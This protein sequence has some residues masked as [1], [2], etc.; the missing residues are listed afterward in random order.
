MYTLCVHVYEWVCYIFRCLFLCMHYCDLEWVHKRG[1][2][3]PTGPTDKLEITFKITQTV[4]V[5][6][7]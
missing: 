1:S 2:L 6:S 4:L 7:A 3:S 5:I